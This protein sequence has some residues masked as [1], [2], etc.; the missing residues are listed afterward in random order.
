VQVG[1]DRLVNALAAFARA[2]GP[3]VVA[4]F[5]TAI[6][7]D[8][9]AADGAFL[10]GAILPGLRTQ[11][12]ALH[13]CCEQL[14]AVEVGMADGAFPEEA[15]PRRAIGTS[16]V[17]AIRAGIAW[18]AAGAARRLVDEIRGELG[19]PAPLLLTGGDA[20]LIRE[21]LGDGEVVPHL[22]LEGVARALLD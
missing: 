19:A 5:G 3:C 9:I 18:G 10:G 12:R 20:P 7:I 2:K 15:V 17:E 21:L 8:A 6:T 14:P 13:D 1:A 16:T 4:A 22:T 11:G